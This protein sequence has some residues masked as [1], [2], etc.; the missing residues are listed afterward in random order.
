[1]RHRV[2]RMMSSEN[3]HTYGVMISPNKK[4]RFRVFR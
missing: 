3:E 4:L 1:M 2:N